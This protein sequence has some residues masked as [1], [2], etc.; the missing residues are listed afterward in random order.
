MNIISPP[1]ESKLKKDSGKGTIDQYLT[2]GKI[3]N[4]VGR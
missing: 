4:E 3:D 2:D 1:K